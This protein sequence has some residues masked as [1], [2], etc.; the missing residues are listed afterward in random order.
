[1]ADEYR[2]KFIKLEQEHIHLLDSQKQHFKSTK[3]ELESA[4]TG[5]I[6]RLEFL[7]KK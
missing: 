4:F 2:Q 7:N 1:M 6:K 3:Y 5:Q